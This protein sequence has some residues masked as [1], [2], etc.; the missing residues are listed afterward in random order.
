LISE[1]GNNDPKL[2]SDPERYTP[3]F[4]AKLMHELRKHSFIGIDAPPKSQES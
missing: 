1:L 2:D 3:P 4:V